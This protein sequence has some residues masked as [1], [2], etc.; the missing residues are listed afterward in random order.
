M[1]TDR[2]TRGH[3]V[4]LLGHVTLLEDDVEHESYTF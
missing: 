3:A 4:Y 2:I 1:K